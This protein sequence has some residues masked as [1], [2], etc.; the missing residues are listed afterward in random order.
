MTLT[1]QQ[2]AYV[3]KNYKTKSKADMKAE[4]KITHQR[5]T[6]FMRAE[7]L[8]GLFEHKGLSNIDPKKKEIVHEGGIFNVRATDNWLV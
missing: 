3:R 6:S 2:A 4:L 8:Q 1:P 5:I 7:N